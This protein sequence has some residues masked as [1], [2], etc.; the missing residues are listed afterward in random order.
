M[1]ARQRLLFIR[2]LAIALVNGLFTLIILLIAPLGLLAVIVNT[3]LVI[4]ASFFVGMVGDQVI[5][6]LLAGFDPT[7]LSEGRGEITYLN[8]ERSIERCDRD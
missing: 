3:F 5:R 7:R 1:L 8:S 2:N 6:W 4:V